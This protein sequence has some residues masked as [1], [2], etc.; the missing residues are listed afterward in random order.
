MAVVSSSGVKTVGVETGG[1]QVAEEAIGP[2]RTGAPA[3]DVTGGV[4]VA[5]GGRVTEDGGVDMTEPETTDTR[6]IGT[7]V[8]PGRGRRL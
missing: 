1:V 3:M 6:L 7:G 8:L 4:V 5:G 2:E